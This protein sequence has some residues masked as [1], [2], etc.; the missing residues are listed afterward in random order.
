MSTTREECE[1]LCSCAPISFTD[2]KLSVAKVTVGDTEITVHDPNEL[3]PNC[4]FG[5]FTGCPSGKPEIFKILNRV[6]NGNG[7]TTMEVLRGL[8][9]TGCDDDTSYPE[10]THEHIYNEQVLI[11]EG[12]IH[13]YF[14][15]IC[16]CLEHIREEIRCVSETIDDLPD[17]PFLGERCIVTGGSCPGLYYYNGTVWTKVSSYNFDSEFFITDGCDVTLNMERLCTVAQNITAAP[18]VYET[19]DGGPGAEYILPTMTFVIDPTFSPTG[20]VAVD[21]LYSVLRLLEAGSFPWAGSKYQILRNGAPLWNYP[22]DYQANT[23]NGNIFG[24]DFEDQ[25]RFCWI[26][27]E[28]VTIELKFIISLTVGYNANTEFTLSEAN[29]ICQLISVC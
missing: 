24:T 28:I 21:L 27:D 12:S 3:I 19:F 9:P 16:E 8:S 26:E 22:M 29:Y 14:C 10:W 25:T 6:Y 15:K 20:K 4:G 23:F 2:F 7:T 1:N 18:G 5:M 17:D 13:Y 11:G